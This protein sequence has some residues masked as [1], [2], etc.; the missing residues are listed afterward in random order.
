MASTTE[1][2]VTTSQAGPSGSA[3]NDQVNQRFITE[4]TEN[5][6]TDRSNYVEEALG[7]YVEQRLRDAELEQQFRSDFARWELSDFNLL[8][9]NLRTR[10]RRFLWH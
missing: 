7:L 1:N 9:R 2:D 10:L 4:D 5:V 6:P 8:S 3:T